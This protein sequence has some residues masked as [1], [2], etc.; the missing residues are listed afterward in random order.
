MRP[1]PSAQ[2]SSGVTI[3]EW[4]MIENFVQ[5]NIFTNNKP[6]L[7]SSP[8]WYIGFDPTLEI[9]GGPNC[10]FGEETY[11]KNGQILTRYIQVFDSSDGL[12]EFY[13]E[14]IDRDDNTE[15]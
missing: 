3:E 8:G 4:K 6:L 12:D 14:R 9:R 15:L 13:V 10:E 5:P 1:W 11:K 7:M 2:M